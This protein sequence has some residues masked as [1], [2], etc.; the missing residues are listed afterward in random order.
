MI[1]SKAS[2]DTNS[3]QFKDT[4]NTNSV[5]HIKVDRRGVGGFTS[6]LY[7]VT[8]LSRGLTFP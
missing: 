7:R 4:V 6:T 5:S 1:F 3:L 2:D 8:E